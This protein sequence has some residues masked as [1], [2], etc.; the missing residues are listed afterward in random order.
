M[1]ARAEELKVGNWGA[2]AAA[3]AVARTVA[4]TI[5]N[6]VIFATASQSRS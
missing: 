2:D 4:A 3:N 5:V 6:S 1:I